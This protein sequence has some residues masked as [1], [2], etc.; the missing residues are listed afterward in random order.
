MP[1]AIKANN[2]FFDLLSADILTRLYTMF[3]ERIDLSPDDV[4]FDAMAIDTEGY[5]ERLPPLWTATVE[6]LADEGFIRIGQASESIDGH[7]A[8]YNVTL[9]GKGIGSLRQDG[10][11]DKLKAAVEQIGTD[12]A[13]KSVTDLVGKVLGWIAKTALGL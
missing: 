12:A 1:K 5:P 2:E 4:N 8:F 9:T 3:P 13:K 6:W 10:T 7:T 11:G